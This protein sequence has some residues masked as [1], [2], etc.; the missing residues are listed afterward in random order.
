M[1]GQ[2]GQQMGQNDFENL[3]GACVQ[4][5][6]HCDAK[7]QPKVSTILGI[8]KAEVF[9]KEPCVGYIKELS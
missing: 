7:G 4:F 1:G 2:F 6:I 3:P 9:F 8:H 5:R